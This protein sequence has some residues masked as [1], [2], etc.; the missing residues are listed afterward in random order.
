[1]KELTF[2]TGNVPMIVAIN[3][4]EKKN[5][6]PQMVHTFVFKPLPMTNNVEGTPATLAAWGDARGFWG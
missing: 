4:C 2:F 3:K 1:M 5:A 6:N